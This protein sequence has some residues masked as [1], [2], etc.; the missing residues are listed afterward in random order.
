MLNSSR[1]VLHSD[2]YLLENTDAYI[3]IARS[4][5]SCQNYL[6]QFA[7]LKF[8]NWAGAYR[9]ISRFPGGLIRPCWFFNVFL[10]IILLLKASDA[11]SISCIGGALE[12]YLLDWSIDFNCPNSDVAY[13]SLQLEIKRKNI[14]L[15]SEVPCFPLVSD[16]TVIMNIFISTEAAQRNYY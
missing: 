1:N 16:V 11:P 9:E 7:A 10:N 8:C 15:N 5:V 14:Q 12:I 2:S 6:H 4:H 3:D 13:I